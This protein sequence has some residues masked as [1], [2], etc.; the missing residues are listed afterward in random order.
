MAKQ[1]LT[2]QQLWQAEQR[3]LN[4]CISCGAEPLLTRNHGAKCAKKIREAAR[5][6]TGAKNRYRGATSYR[7]VSK[8]LV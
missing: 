2:R 8:K 6:R 5:K 3:K 4:L 7:R 1:K